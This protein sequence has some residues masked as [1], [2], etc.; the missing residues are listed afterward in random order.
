MI[1]IEGVF[2]LSGLI[3]SIAAAILYYR[4][5]RYVFNKNVRRVLG[6]VIHVSIAKYL[7]NTVEWSGLEGGISLDSLEDY[8]D[9]IWPFAWFLFFFAALMDASSLRLR[10]SEKRY[11][12][13]FNSSR[14][15]IALIDSGGRF[16]EFNNTTKALTGYNQAELAQISIDTLFRS[17]GDPDKG[18]SPR[19][20]QAPP[21]YREAILHRKNG[22][23]LE[24]EFIS[25]PVTVNSRNATY[26]RIS[27]ITQ[28]KAAERSLAESR[29]IK[30]RW[31]K[32]DSLGLMAGGVAHDLNNILSGVINYPELILMDLPE[33]SPLRKPVEVMLHSGKKAAEGVQDLI[34]VARG[35]ANARTPLNLN[36][37]IAE[38]LESS[39]H[40]HLM[41]S[42]AQVSIER[43]LDERLMNLKGSGIHVRKLVMNLVANAV[44]AIEG[45][46]T[47]VVQTANRRLWKELNAYEIIEPG[48]YAVLSV[49]DNGS[50]I[51]SVD[52]NR[53]FEPFY[54]KK[55]LGRSGTGLG[56]T[57][58]WNVA[59]DHKGYIDVKSDHDGT[60][61]EIFF[62]G[63]SEKVVSVEMDEPIEKY[64][65]SGETVLVVDDLEI[66]R[67]IVCTMLTRLGYKAE[68]V[69]SGE[70][71]IAF[72]KRNPAHLILLDM[73]MEPGING[74]QTFEEIVKINHHQKA[75]V[76][77]GYAETD[78]VKAVLRSGAA[79]F[80]K[81]P[82]TLRG[83]GVA[84]HDE[85]RPRK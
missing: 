37:I 7:V 46:G 4:G 14:D 75:I 9:D 35:V 34:T 55:I 65:G 79:R 72:I 18:T 20:G 59:K 80:L 29:V 58:V 52:I 68:S 53:I 81:K 64:K 84:V 26:I 1:T 38:Y 27:D 61:F 11:R 16:I 85:L 21:S 66:Q 74:R 19:S 73:L 76:M 54:T 6:I 12:T 25:E 56:L 83:L 62:P 13:L 3:G 5:G 24:T 15:A 2:E 77:S 57:V 31:E 39:E 10:E 82:L 70:D 51:T 78:D 30:E 42:N 17:P 43:R 28:R 63:T 36:Q 44:E 49:S 40:D 71:A 69:S 33:N 67:D 50:G 8:L 32:M 41:K 22:E 48:E 47:V 60:A 23:A 45:N